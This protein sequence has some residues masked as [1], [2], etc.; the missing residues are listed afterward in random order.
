MRLLHAL[1]EETTEV[2]AKVTDTGLR[3]KSHWTQ[4]PKVLIAS[5]QAVRYFF[6]D[7]A[8]DEDA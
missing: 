6:V 8:V 2:A 7:A 4:L 1:P 5:L 3:G